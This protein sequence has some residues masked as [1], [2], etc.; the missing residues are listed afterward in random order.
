MELKTLNITLSTHTHT[1][2]YM[3]A[4]M[5]ANTFSYERK[6]AGETER[7]KTKSCSACKSINLNLLDTEEKL[8][9]KH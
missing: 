1:L 4:F 7:Q 8:W 9:K 5:Q 6:K 2:N 3:L